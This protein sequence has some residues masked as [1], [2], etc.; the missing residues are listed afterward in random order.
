MI[1]S[2]RTGLAS[3]ACLARLERARNGPTLP[4]L[5]SL[6]R[7]VRRLFGNV[8]P[9]SFRLRGAPAFLALVEAVGTL[10]PDAGGTRI[11]IRY[12]SPPHLVA[13]FLAAVAVAGLAALL[14]G[15]FAP[16][17]QTNARRLLLADPADLL[18]FLAVVDGALVLT[19]A[20]FARRW[21]RQEAE[22]LRALL[23]RT[24]EATA[25]R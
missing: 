18:T 15:L 6:S 16:F 2:L 3:D 5:V 21:A 9:S 25:A 23:H 7:R 10:T 11:E 4:Y 12:G 24:L 20:A 1:E 14:L 13:A 22:E 8:G 17:A 19:V